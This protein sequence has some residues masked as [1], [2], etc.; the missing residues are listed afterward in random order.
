MSCDTVCSTSP[1]YHNATINNNIIG[2]NHI[3]TTTQSPPYAKGWT[4][5]NDACM[6]E[7][8]YTLPLTPR[9]AKVPISVGEAL[10]RYND[11]LYLVQDPAPVLG[12]L[13]V[14]MNGVNVYGLG[15]ACGFS[16]NCPNTDPS[17][18]STYVDAVESEGHTVDNCGGH[19]DPM[20]FYHV[21]QIAN[22]LTVSQREACKLPPD[23]AGNHSELL[24]WLLDG[25]GLYGPFSQGGVMPTQLDECGGHTHEIDGIMTYH[26]H[27]PDS[28]PWIIGCFKGCPE[29]SKNAMISAVANTATYGCPEW[30]TEDP[31]PLFEQLGSTESG[32]NAA[33]RQALPSTFMQIVM[34]GVLAFLISSSLC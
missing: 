4:N 25:F 34:C 30:L 13:G 21:H 33:G 8:T 16:S 2:D 15:S 26:Y 22:L 3:V 23:T 28:F 7:K 9:Y 20:G 6:I 10:E 29:A 27:L 32:G 5:P 1:P 14:L 17:A 18:P 24:E 12:S 19:A 31:N 11:I